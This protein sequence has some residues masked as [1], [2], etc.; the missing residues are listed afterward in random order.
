MDPKQRI[1]EI[2]NITDTLSPTFCLAKWHHTTIY[3]QSGETHSCYH[4]APHTIPLEEI[5]NNP[6]A[7]HNTNEKKLQR[8]EMLNGAK[9]SG[10]QYCWNRPLRS[11]L[12]RCRKSRSLSRRLP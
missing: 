11:A 2:K 8:L 3:L 12:S 9:P 5:A 4:P 1:I 10:C 6:S 7:I